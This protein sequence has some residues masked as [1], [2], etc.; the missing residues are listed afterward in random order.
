MSQQAANP[1]GDRRNVVIAALTGIAVVL[2]VVIY[3]SP[4]WWVALRAPQYPAEAFPEGI[5]IHFHMNGVFNGCPKVEKKEIE[6]DIVLDCV[7][8]MDAINHFVGMYPVGAGGPVEK[9]FSPFLLIF[10]ALLLIGFAMPDRRLRLVVTMA[11]WAVMVGWMWAAMKMDDGVR[12]LPESYLHSLVV[13]LGEGEEEAGEPLSPIIARLEEELRRSGAGFVESRRVREQ[14]ER[15]G[16]RELAGALAELAR[17]GAGTG[18]RSLKEILEEARERGAG[19]DTW[20]SVLKAAFE[21]DQ[22]RKPPEER[23]S[24]NGSGLQVVL[25]HYEKTLK[26]WFNEPERNEPLARAMTAAAHGLFWALVVVPPVLFFLG[27]YGPPLFY[28]LMGV[29]P[30]L[31]P[32]AF[33]VEYSAWLYWF[34]HNMSELGAFTLKPFMPT[35]F[36]QGKVA[37]FTTHSYPHYGFAL[38]VLF[39]LIVVLIILLRRK[40]LREAQRARTA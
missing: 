36:G 34:G 6:E 22:A 7:H 25:W 3:Y 2:L 40:Q 11:G 29:I 18:E 20:I 15:A 26:R 5:R 16:E 35:V 9:A 37:Q 17:G 1:A 23:Q 33:V 31:L 27:S 39:A 12:L 8:E 32:V 19:K 28:W 10:L 38:M 30:A 24:W 14:L 21:T 4:V 13:A